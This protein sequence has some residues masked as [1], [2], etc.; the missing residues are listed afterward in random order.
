MDDS[1]KVL[2]Q[3]YMNLKE[4]NSP[5]KKKHNKV[6]LPKLK[7]EEA[8]ENVTNSSPG[9]LKRLKRKVLPGY[10]IATL[11]ATMEF[12]D[13]QSY[14]KKVVGADGEA[15][16]VPFGVCDDLEETK[17]FGL[18][19]Y[20]YLELIKRLMLTFIFLSILVGAEL[21]F[22]YSGTGL[23]AYTASFTLTLAKFTLGNLSNADRTTYLIITIFDILTMVALFA[24]YVH[25]RLFLNSVIEESERNHDI[26]NPT[27]YAVSVSGF[28]KD[29][30]NLEDNLKAYFDGLYRGAHEVEV[31]Y[32]YNRNFKKFV[33]YDEAIEAVEK[34][35]QILKQTEKDGE[36]LKEYEA[37]LEKIEDEIEAISEEFEPLYAIVH[38]RNLKAKYSFINMCKKYALVNKLSY[39]LRRCLCC[40]PQQPERQRFLGKEEIL[41]ESTDL[42]RPEEYNWPNMDISLCSKVVRVILSVLLL[43][44]VIAITSSL[45]VFCTLYVSTTSSCANYDANTSL[46]QALAGDSQTLFCYCN[47]NF[48]LIYVD[49]SIQNACTNIER[50]I[51]VSNLLQVGA[52]L[53]SAI[54]NVILIVIVALIAE[55]LLKPATKPG[56]YSFI[57]VGVLISNYINSTLLP[58]ILNGNIFGFKSVTYLQWVS[59]ID[60]NRL[61]IFSDFDRDWFAIISPYYTNFFIIAAVLPPIQLLVF[62]LKRS[63]LVWWVERKCEN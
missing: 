39:K 51:L 56:E 50:D 37:E 47:A 5:D 57:F 29:T 40:M 35:K 1:S 44:V 61:S 55:Y 43:I 34:E 14:R 33:S 49:S 8:E 48:H 10:E 31:V 21:V 30:P 15:E 23:S 38:F 46:T 4:D 28:S 7:T 63:L 6:I 58:L 41:I 17:E 11:D 22:N 9:K 32:D 16:Y 25:W 52:S 2:D 42:A 60:L 13:T 62:C 24:F 53:V 12:L 26:V 19:I 36:D 18:G 45:I 54:T 27:L 59:F 3:S 20:L